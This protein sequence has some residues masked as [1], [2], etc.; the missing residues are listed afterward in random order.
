MS[1]L[2]GSLRVA[3]SLAW[4]PSGVAVVVL[5]ALAAAPSYM[6]ASRALQQ[7]PPGTGPLATGLAASVAI[8]LA[9]V[10]FCLLFPLLVVVSRRILRV[11]NTVDRIRVTS[12]RM[13]AWYHALL[14]TEA[15]NRLAGPLLRALGLYRWFARGMGMKVGRGSLLNTTQMYDHDLIEVGAGVVVG[16][17]AVLTGHVV[18][19]GYLVR[20]RIAIG[21]GAVIGLH[22]V[23]LP[24]C[25]IGAGCHVGAMAL[26]PKDAVLAPGRCY[27]GVPARD[28]GPVPG[29]GPA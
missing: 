13:L 10:Q 20:K 1:P 16:G 5:F 21:D 25:V 27:G 3:A 11:H 18:E 24:G 23:L 6:L 14:C 19:G 12:P 9:Y 7:L 28:I 22:A 8:A 15:V 29:A 17:D 2:R 26:V 4:I